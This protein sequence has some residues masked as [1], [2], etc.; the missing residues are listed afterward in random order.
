LD[1]NQIKPMTPPAMPHAKNNT[2]GNTIQ[3]ALLEPLCSNAQAGY[4]LAL[5][6]VATESTRLPS[7]MAKIPTAKSTL[8]VS[9]TSGGD[10]ATPR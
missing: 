3:S 1:E 6:A 7:A 4:P 10:G 5:I 8:R 9:R 2:S